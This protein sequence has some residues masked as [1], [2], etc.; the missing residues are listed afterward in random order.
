[1]ALEEH[2][3]EY[4]AKRIAEH[5]ARDLAVPSSDSEIALEVFLASWEASALPYE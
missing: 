1:M 3:E 2:E 5:A 4:A